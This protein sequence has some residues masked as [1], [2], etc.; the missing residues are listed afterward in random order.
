FLDGSFSSLNFASRALPRAKTGSGA[1]ANETATDPNP[2]SAQ[3]NLPI[4]H[5]YRQVVVDRSITKVSAKAEPMRPSVSPCQRKVGTA[6]HQARKS[7][8]SLH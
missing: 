1:A 8:I 3:D 6:N 2:L 7:R 4:I 5:T